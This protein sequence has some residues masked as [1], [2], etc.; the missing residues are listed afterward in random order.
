MRPLSFFYGYV[1]LS[2]CFF[3]MFLMRG[4][5][6][7]FGVFYVAL[8]ADF[9]WSRA[10]AASIASINA[11]VYAVSSPLVGWAF[12]RLGPRMLMPLGGL[13]IGAGLFFSGRS[14]T[15]WEFYLFYG[16]VVGT[17]LA[18][19]GF[20]SNS[21]LISHWF[22]R[23]RGTAIGV[24]TMGLG[25]GL[26]VIVPLMQVLISHF[27]WRAAFMVAGVVMLLTIVPANL[28]LQRGRPEDLG[29]LPDGAEKVRD[30][31]PGSAR[32]TK[33]LPVPGWTVRTAIRSTPFWSIA[34][35][36]L[37]LGTGVSLIYTHVVAHLVHV[38]LDAFRAA[39]MLGLVGL[40]RM[41]G[42]TL[43]GV[44]SDRLGRD[45]AY[46]LATVVTLTGIGILIVLSPRSSPWLVYTFVIFYGLGHSAGNPTYGA[47]IAD[48]FGGKKIGTILGFLEITFGI[49]MAFGPWFGGFVYDITG[50]YRWAFVVGLAAFFLSFLSVYTSLAW[51]RRFQLRTQAVGMAASG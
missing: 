41:P 22:V 3:N 38:G 51:R 26:L 34:M 31:Q 24:A 8:L 30:E 1:I 15:L 16:I 18:G 28:L 27:G 37:A 19:I 44:V 2:L 42:T 5:L 39:S 25:F 36:H 32:A 17:G 49:G 13:L 40:V 45:R 50:S 48:I 47:T 23:R 21:A 46:G 12:D 9:E 43:W 4:V 35:G 11:L 6:G 29:Q 14:Q 33:F 7:S 10:S 20:V